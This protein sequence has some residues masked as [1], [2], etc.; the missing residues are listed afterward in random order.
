MTGTRIHGRNAVLKLGPT[1]AVLADVSGD[2]NDI[3]LDITE[4]TFD[5]TG[6][7]VDWQDNDAGHKSFKLSAKLFNARGAQQVTSIAV[8][9]GGSGYVSAPS[10][11]ITPGAGGGTGAAATSV[12]ENGAVTKVVVTAGG[13]GYGSV[14]TISFSGGSGSNAAATAVVGQWAEQVLWPL[15][16][17]DTVYFEFQPVGTGTGKPS[18]K[19]AFVKTAFKPNSPLKG[20]AMV[21]ISGTGKGTLTPSVQA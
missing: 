12:I 2:S 6:Y 21:E 11:T 9:N 19:G 7:G 13:S 17:L 5:S 4:E 14:P 20:G 1:A 18:W 3:T 8:T 16:E 10:V 15:L